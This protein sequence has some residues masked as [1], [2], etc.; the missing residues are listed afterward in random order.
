MNPREKADIVSRHPNE[1]RKNY[2]CSL[3]RTRF[4]SRPA[5]RDHIDDVHP[6][7]LVFILKKV[8]TVQPITTISGESDDV[9]YDE[10]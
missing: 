6:D 3:C 9:A 2:F 10:D 5:V 8:E 4:G 7:K 1:D